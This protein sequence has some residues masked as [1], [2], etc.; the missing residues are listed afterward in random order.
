MDVTQLPFNQWLGLTVCDDTICLLP[1][2]QHLNHVETVHAAVIFGVAEAAAGH[3]L[4][5]RYPQLEQSH[6]ALLRQ[7]SV[8]Y[9][10]PA[11]AGIDL[12]GSA[13]CDEATAA[14]FLKNLQERGRG[15]L[16]ISAAVHQADNKILQATFGWFASKRGERS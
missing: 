10:Q 12:T 14:I 15:V 5:Q 9:R 8:K 16:E 2:P 13:T 4:S 3:W 11:V 7:S 6:V 1:Q